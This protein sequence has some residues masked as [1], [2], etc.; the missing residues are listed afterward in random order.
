MLGELAHAVVAKA[1]RFAAW[2]ED[3][4]GRGRVRIGYR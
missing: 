1:R 3:G 4:G 2:G